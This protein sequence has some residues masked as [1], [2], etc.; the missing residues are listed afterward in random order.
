M[1]RGATSAAL[2]ELARER[3]TPAHLVTLFIDS[4]AWRR[5]TAHRDIVWSANTWIA[6]GDL[7]SVGDIEETADL[8]VPQ[9]ALVAGGVTADQVSL[10]LSE[11]LVERRVEIH[12]AFL[13]DAD[14]LVADPVLVFEG[15]IESHQLEDDPD[16]GTA[17]VR[18]A[19]S[20]HWADFHRRAGRTTNPADQA[21]WFPGDLGLDYVAQADRQIPWGS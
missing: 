8:Q 4:G 16:S 10:V 11:H 3:N 14:A 17:S 2:A 21:I 7:I 18:I 5:T 15:R 13:S 6:A 12:M 9:V 20:S 1:T 19:V